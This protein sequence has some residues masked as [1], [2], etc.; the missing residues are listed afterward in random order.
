MFLACRHW[1]SSFF[2]H[3]P[4]GFPSCLAVLLEPTSISIFNSCSSTQEQSSLSQHPKLNVCISAKHHVQ[5]TKACLA[6]VLTS[7][8]GN[9]HDGWI[10]TVLLHIFLEGKAHR[11]FRH[12]PGGIF[13]SGTSGRTLGPSPGQRFCCCQFLWWLSQR[14]KFK[15]QPNPNNSWSISLYGAKTKFLKE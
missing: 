15:T 1:V 2:L 14:L 9:R 10:Q 7:L 5:F 13:F 12:C 3:V 8:S 4:P 6:T 11:P